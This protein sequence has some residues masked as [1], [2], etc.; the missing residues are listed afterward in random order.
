MQRRTVI[1]SPIGALTLTADESGRLT[2]LTMSGWY[3]HSGERRPNDDRQ[4]FETV[5]TQLDEYFAGEREHFDV[6][7]AP[8]GNQFQRSVWKLLEEIPYGQ[9]RSYGALAEALGDKTLARAVGTA[10][11]SNPIAVIVPC[12]RVIGTDGQLTGFGGGLDRK[13]FL[14]HLENPSRPL[15]PRL[16]A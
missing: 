4:G 8:S 2:G 13:E 7:L 16:F 15:R 1:D 9:T 10:C 6:E 5:I 3:Q 12:H 11:G 14:L